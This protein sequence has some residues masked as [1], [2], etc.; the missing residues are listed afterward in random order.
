MEL[1]YPPKIILAWGE[2]ISG[3][4][5]IRDWLIKNG[6]PELGLFVFALHLKQDAREWLM[7][8]GHAA[9][10]AL[11]HGAEGNKEALKW[12]EKN[13]YV[14]LLKMAQG[15]DNDDK[16]IAWLVEKGFPDFA[17]I[18]QKIRYVKN[19]IESDHNDVHKFSPE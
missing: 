16:A 5:Q 1:A 17:V 15:A 14:L 13:Q 12:L 19:D 6:Y 4:N 9:L 7:K 8:K 11:I 2:A 10:F 18:A 3:N